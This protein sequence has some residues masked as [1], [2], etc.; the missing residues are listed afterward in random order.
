MD[1]FELLNREVD[2]KDTDKEDEREKERRRR[3]KPDRTWPNTQY[4]LEGLWFGFRKPALSECKA[5][6]AKNLKSVNGTENIV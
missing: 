2:K 1:L 5:F 6:F 4:L 3:R